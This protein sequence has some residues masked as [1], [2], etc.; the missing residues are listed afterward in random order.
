MG[1][2]TS[3]VRGVNGLV[4]LNVGYTF[5]CVLGHKVLVTYVVRK[6]EVMMSMTEH[7]GVSLWVP[8]LSFPAYAP[9][10]VTE[11]L[12]TPRFGDKPPP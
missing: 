11:Q 4:H 5:Q 3:M 6:M 8:V 2:L 1:H 12:M 10:L 7:T 9:L